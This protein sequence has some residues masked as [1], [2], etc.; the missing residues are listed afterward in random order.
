MPLQPGPATTRRT[1]LGACGLSLLAA[2][3]GTAGRSP[4]A[5]DDP[6]QGVVDEA[7]LLS[8]TALA[9]VRAA[10]RRH[11]SLAGRVQPLA[12]LHRAHLAVLPEPTTPAVPVEPGG[13]PAATL[14]LVTELERDTWRRLTDLAVAAESGALA[15]LLA[16]MSAGIVAHLGSGAGG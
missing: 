11:P 14:A 2:G 15:R 3:C 9:S 13:R 6:D 10:A 1:A 4:D 8:A 12:A 5:A 16:S 7:V